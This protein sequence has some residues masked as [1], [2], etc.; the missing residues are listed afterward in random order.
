MVFGFGN[1][2][3]ASFDPVIGNFTSFTPIP[4]SFG[5]ERVRIADLNGD[6]SNDVVIAGV[7]ASGLYWLQNLETGTTS[8]T[9]SVQLN[10]SPAAGGALCGSSLP[11]TFISTGN[12]FWSFDPP[13]FATDTL[14]IDPGDFPIGTEIDLYTFAPVTPQDSCPGWVMETYVIDVC[15]D[16]QD[17]ATIPSIQLTPNPTTSTTTVQFDGLSLVKLI[18]HDATG[19]AV[20][21]ENARSPHTIDVSAWPSGIYS[22]SVLGEEQRTVRLVKE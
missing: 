21:Q 13:V 9:P 10:G 19:R 15:T 4:N 3:V 5:S 12:E 16:V 20:L 2:G 1:Y 6:G 11:A 18:V 17:L 22:I 8:T 7:S 14:V